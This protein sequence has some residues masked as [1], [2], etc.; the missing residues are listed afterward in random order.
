MK[1]QCDAIV[2]RRDTY[3]YTGG[4]PSGFAMHYAKGQCERRAVE[5]GLCR[6]HAK[7]SAYVRRW[8]SLWARPR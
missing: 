4:T 5:D 1:T 2:W 6:Q 7:K 8:S 3:R